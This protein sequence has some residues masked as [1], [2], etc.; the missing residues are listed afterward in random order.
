MLRWFVVGWAFFN[1]TSELIHAFGNLEPP[2]NSSKLPPCKACKTFVE[3]FKKVSLNSFNS[4][5]TLICEVKL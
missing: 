2:T 4:S 3:S 5:M 1:I